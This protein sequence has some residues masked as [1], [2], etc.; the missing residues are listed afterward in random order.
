MLPRRRWLNF[1]IAAAAFATLLGALHFLH[2]GRSEQFKAQPIPTNPDAGLAEL[3]LGNARFFQSARTLSTD[4]AHD[5]ENRHQTAKKKNP[6]AV[7]LC[8]S[9]S[10]I[11]P[12]FIFDQ[13][14]GS[15]FEVRNAGNIVDE[16]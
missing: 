10:R 12:E 8:C 16:D 14:P 6:F 13:R 3:R 4:T 15:I 5:A 7:I 9:D 11:C 2:S 1:A